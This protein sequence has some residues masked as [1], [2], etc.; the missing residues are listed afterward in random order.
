MPDPSQDDGSRDCLASE[1]KM[2]GF[3]PAISAINHSALQPRAGLRSRRA[4]GRTVGLVM[5]SLAREI[6][7]WQSRVRKYGD[8]PLGFSV[9]V[10]P[11]MNDDHFNAISP[12]VL[13][14]TA[15]VP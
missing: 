8:R 3:A 1:N 13:A 14:G 15:L 7:E 10:G 2:A 9:Y 5:R 11:E 12:T 4:A 6:V